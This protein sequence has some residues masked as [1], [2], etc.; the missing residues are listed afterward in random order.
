M[1]ID[2]QSDLEN[3]LENIAEKC[4]MGSEKLCK[5]ILDTWLKHDGSVWK[6]RKKIVVDWPAGFVFVDLK[7]VA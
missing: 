6:G 4:G 5:L 2:I 7:E 1:N 3:K